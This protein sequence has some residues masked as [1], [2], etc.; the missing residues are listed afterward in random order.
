MVAV[1]V[2]GAGWQRSDPEIEPEVQMN[3][4]TFGLKIPERVIC[5][6]DRYEG[7]SS[8]CHGY[9]KIE[10]IN[11]TL[12]D[13]DDF[14][15]GEKAVWRWESDEMEEEDLLERHPKDD[16]LL[17]PTTELEPPY[18]LRIT[19]S[20][21]RSIGTIKSNP[22]LEHKTA[23]IEIYQNEVEEFDIQRYN[24]ED[25]NYSSSFTISNPFPIPMDFT[26]N[27]EGIRVDGRNK[28]EYTWGCDITQEPR[29]VV[30]CQ[31]EGYTQ[32][33]LPKISTVTSDFIADSSSVNN[34]LNLQLNGEFTVDDFHNLMVN[35][36]LQRATTNERFPYL[37][38]Y[39]RVNSKLEIIQGEN[40]NEV[41]LSFPEL[42]P[43]K[44]RFQAAFSILGTEF[45]FEQMIADVLPPP[46]NLDLL[47]LTRQRHYVL[48]LDLAVKVEN[49]LSDIASFNFQDL[50]FDGGDINYLYFDCSEKRHQGHPILKIEL[51]LF[52]E[53]TTDWLRQ[54]GRLS[55]SLVA[56]HK[57]GLMAKTK[58]SWSVFSSGTI[59]TCLGLHAPDPDDKKSVYYGEQKNFPSGTVWCKYI[60]RFSRFSMDDNEM[61]HE[62]HEIESVF[63]HRGKGDVRFIDTRSVGRYSKPSKRQTRKS[64]NNLDNCIIEF[65]NLENKDLIDRFS[66]LIFIIDDKYWYP[67]KYF[68]YKRE[69]SN[70]QR[71]FY[72]MD[73]EK[74]RTLRKSLKHL[75]TDFQHQNKQRNSCYSTTQE[76]SGS[77]Y[78]TRQN[79]TLEFSIDRVKITDLKHNITPIQ[80]RKEILEEI[81]DLELRLADERQRR[82]E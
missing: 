59:I 56:Q 23:E 19:N 37:M 44:Y 70:L 65:Q 28:Y 13:L 24:S 81:V 18:R 68:V 64:L 1:F 51:P 8:E 77:S 79:G 49:S 17:K 6:A 27:G 47:F 73:Y 15:F 31:A 10:I 80:T 9:I 67:A 4:Q 43:G 41:R 58:I 54:G 29:F 82:G 2:Q 48:E 75:D 30:K 74:G 11:D 14:F 45:S 78:S 16:I 72:P 34:G 38:E 71:V 20:D 69:G 42:E 60:P 21:Y 61:V 52:D 66:E 26:I 63:L 39:N 7:Y 32:V 50:N 35:S 53:Q 76:F 22:I 36:E 3:L 40:A 33:V 57:S 46:I 5:D 25:G 55:V 62:S 12:V